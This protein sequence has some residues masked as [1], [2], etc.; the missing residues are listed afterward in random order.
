[1]KNSKT[2][3][4]KRSVA[5]A[6]AEPQ[7]NPWVW[8]YAVSAVVALIA[9][10]EVYWPAMHGPFLLD[11]TYMTY[12]RPD[13]AR[14][15]FSGWVHQMRPLLFATFWWNYQQ[16]GAGE[17]FGYHVVN[18]LLHLANTVFIF[19]AI[20]KLAGW[21]GEAEWRCGVLALFAAGLFLLHPLQTESVSYIA[22]RSETLSVFFVLAALVVFLY[23][24]G[25][26]LTIGRVLALLA[27]FAAAALSKEHT[28]V[29]P[30]LFLLTDYYWGFEFAPSTTWRNWK[31]YVPIAAAAAVALASTW[32]VLRGNQSAGFQMRGLNWYQ[33]FFTECRVIWDYIRLY[34][35]PFG[36]NLDPDIKISR[37]ILSHG[38]IIGLAGLI[39]VSVLAWIYRRRFPLGSY[40]WFIFIIL[41]AP[42]SSFVPIRDPMAERRL[43]LP[44]IGLLLITVEFLRRWKASRNTVIAVLAVIL[45]AEGTVTYQRNLLWGSEI[46][47]WKD[48]VAKSPKKLRPRFQLAMADFHA[49]ACTDA[50]DEFQ[51]ASELERPKYDLLLDWGLAYDCAG[52]S[53]QAIAKFQE[54]A[55]LHPSGHTYSQLGMEYGKSSKYAEALDALTTAQR[56]DPGF[57]MTY[58]TLGD[59]HL[60]Q[61]DPVQARENYQQAVALDPN[62]LPAREA[63]ARLPAV[64]PAPTP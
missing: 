51:K 31:L 54:A 61:G 3:K 63:L 23:R 8:I 22:S 58:K 17:T 45:A 44:F 38:A 14:V 55:A 1:M 24:K 26:T 4:A 27:L 33:Y 15:H 2:K 37:S 35:F 30:A 6:A 52:N 48:T 36:Q 64:S 42:T 10:F 29:L 21:A 60:A 18:L 28:A 13:A 16:S 50:V 12:M 46:D 25:A 39:A 7:T 47:I 59:V 62:N 32:R 57:S 5:V 53:A 43:Y 49:A 40:G 34:V 20:R 41:L 19:L 56:L 9:A 11:D